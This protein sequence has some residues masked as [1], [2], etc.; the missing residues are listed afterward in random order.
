MYCLHLIIS[1]AILTTNTHT[2]LHTQ[3]LTHTYT[4]PYT[5]LWSSTELLNIE[6]YSWSWGGS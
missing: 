5:S 4:H 2:Y 3:I 6:T 1:L